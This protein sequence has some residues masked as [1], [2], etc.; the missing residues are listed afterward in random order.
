MLTSYASITT[1]LLHHFLCEIIPDLVRLVPPVQQNNRDNRNGVT[2]AEG[3]E[4]E[5]QT[6]LILQQQLW[7]TTQVAATATDDS[8]LVLAVLRILGWM[9]SALLTA[10]CPGTLGE[11][12][13]APP[14]PP[15]PLKHAMDDG[16][17]YGD[18]DTDE[19]EDA[20]VESHDSLHNNAASDAFLRFVNVWVSL[21]QYLLTSFQ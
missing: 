19:D 3:E 6:E 12:H 15:A 20:G 18:M 7:T 13:F 1:A 5:E 2:Y 16:D 10:R 11:T 9:F 4:E 8:S 21:M 14:F 17:A